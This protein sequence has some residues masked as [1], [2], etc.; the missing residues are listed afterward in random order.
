M[1]GK[2]DESQTVCCKKI[3]L[4]KS[5]S[6]TH[7]KRRGKKKNPK[8]LKKTKGLVPAL[9]H[10][11]KDPALAQLW[12]RFSPLPRNFHMQWVRPKKK[13]KQ[14]LKEH[15]VFLWAQWVKDLGLS[16]LWHGFHPWYGNFRMLWALPKKGKKQTKTKQKKPQRNN[17]KKA[18]KEKVKFI[19]VKGLEEG[20]RVR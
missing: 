15:G 11:V 16:Q 13:T 10:W 3:Y 12:L 6:L 4:S 9:V 14:T 2:R 7:K 5:N 19:K 8:N 20:E 17:N 18:T 1:N